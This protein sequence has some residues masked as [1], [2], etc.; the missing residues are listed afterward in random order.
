[1]QGS[2]WVSKGCWSYAPAVARSSD[3]EFVTLPLHPGKYRMKAK[4]HRFW[5]VLECVWNLEQWHQI[6]RTVFV[7]MMMMMMSSFAKRNWRNILMYGNIL[8]VWLN[9]WDS[10]STHWSLMLFSSFGWW[11]CFKCC[12][13][14]VVAQQTKLETYPLEW[15]WWLAESWQSFLN[16]PLHYPTVSHLNSWGSCCITGNRYIESNTAILNA[17]HIISFYFT[18]DYFI[19][20]LIKNNI[21]IYIYLLTIS[22]KG[23]HCFCEAAAEGGKEWILG[24]QLSAR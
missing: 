5:R 17:T 10:I 21:Y 24:P 19:S 4:L 20:F 12:E 2:V 6:G 18:L 7:M 22:W 14:L 3:V 13:H 1:M 23:P 16:N 8:N 15:S 11:K 9:I